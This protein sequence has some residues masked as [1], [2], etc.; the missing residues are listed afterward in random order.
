VFVQVSLIPGLLDLGFHSSG[1]RAMQYEQRSR[2]LPMNIFGPK[3]R[4]HPYVSVAQLTMLSQLDGFLAGTSSV[5]ML[6]HPLIKPDAVLNMDSGTGTLHRNHCS[7][8]QS[9]CWPLQFSFVQFP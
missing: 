6:K 3:C 1:L 4:F 2:G 7:P 8:S 5:L 9:V